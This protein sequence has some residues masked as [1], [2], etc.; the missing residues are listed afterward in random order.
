MIKFGDMQYIRPDMD[1]IKKEMEEILEGLSSS[2]S[3][4]EEDSLFDDFIRISRSYDTMATLVSIRNSV[5]TL[6]EFYDKENDFFDEVGP[7]FKALRTRFYRAMLDSSFTSE[8][9]EKRGEHIFNLYRLRMSTFSD[10]VLDDL[11]E[12][13]KL[14]S[15]YVK[16]LGGAKIMFEGEERSL[17]Q[18]GPFMNDDDRD[19]RK[20]ATDAYFGYFEENLDDFDSIYDSLV[21]T[22]DGIAKKL[23]FEN[24]VELG[25]ARLQRTDYGKDDVAKF[26]EGVKKHIVPVAIE[27]MERQKERL[28]LDK[29]SYYDMNYSFSSGN[30][31]PHGDSDWILEKGVKMYD[32]LSEETG[33][34]FRFMKDAELL[35]LVSKK[36]KAPG[37]YCTYIEDYDSPFIFSNFNGTLDDVTVLTHEVGHA[38]EVYNSRGYSLPDYRFPT[39]EAAEIHSMGMEYITW[40]WMKEFFEEETEKFLF[41][42]SHDNLVFI[43]YGVTVDEFQHWVY[44]NPEATPLERRNKWREIEKIYT[45]YKN[46]EGNE[47]LESGGFWQRQGHIFGSPFYYIDYTLAAIVSF[48]IYSAFE[49]DRKKAWEDYV[50]VCKVGGS[51]PF[52]EI[53]KVGS[54]K[55]PF[56]E[57]VVKASVKDIA[58][59]VRSVDDTRF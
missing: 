27:L 2:T 44:E 24:F 36:G 51:R 1:Q 39:L 21:K 34:F 20:R 42:H 54:Y 14:K 18:M 53:L 11:K 58:D 7:E 31:K 48:Q 52:L 16:L 57:E 49:K 19:M 10:E 9:K 23:G 46:Y 56:D 6:D 12:E 37:G 5:D 29:L 3:F 8:H 41:K 45:P 17:S 40:P 55:N 38:F 26:R 50:N 59:Y 4:E 28:A 32:E 22:R 13:N 25:Y 47:Y 30:P 33:E 43:P 15:K 35:D